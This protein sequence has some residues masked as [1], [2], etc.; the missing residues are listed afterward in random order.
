MYQGKKVGG[1]VVSID[2]ETH[3]NSLDLFFISTEHHNSG[4]GYAA[5]NAIEARYPVTP[6]FEK[7][8]IHFYVNKCGFHI[9]EFYNEQNPDPYC[10][11]GHV[12]EMPESLED[13]MFRFEKV[14]GK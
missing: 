10:D 6:Y 14:M 8:N 13:G 7:R 2:K 12:N 3:H 11:N 9:V 1:V 5:W 4:L